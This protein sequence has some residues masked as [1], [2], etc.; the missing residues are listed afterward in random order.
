[1]SGTYIQRRIKPYKRGK[2]RRDKRGR[3]KSKAK[4]KSHM[5]NVR[6]WG[7]MKGIPLE[8]VVKFNRNPHFN[9]GDEIQPEETMGKKEKVIGTGV[10]HAFEYLPYKPITYGA[11]NKQKNVEVISWL[12]INK[13][14]A[15]ARKMVSGDNRIAYIAF[16]RAYNM[17]FKILKA[18]IL[19]GIKY[20]EDNHL[21]NIPQRT[22]KLRSAIMNSLNDSVN[23]MKGFPI[24]IK[25]GATDVKYA[26]VVHNYDSS[27]RLSHKPGINKIVGSKDK[28]LKKPSIITK[29]TL[30][31]NELA[32]KFARRSKYFKKNASSY[33]YNAM[34]GD[35]FA[36]HQFMNNACGFLHL[37]IKYGLNKVLKTKL[38]YGKLFI[39]PEV[40]NILYDVYYTNPWRG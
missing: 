11:L 22:G 12:A 27:I 13:I 40:L 28:R 17:L 8:T 30:R 29:Q 33:S 6:N 18:A 20:F 25:M 37:S 9:Y 15:D 38:L 31:V 34:K 5:R 2:Q 14:P 32:N 24:T 36:S 1:M 3:F 19:I 23:N 10:K 21:K 16:V 4:V 7:A 39:S 26:T 35:P